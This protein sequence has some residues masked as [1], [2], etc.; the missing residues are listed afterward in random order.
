MVP[1]PALD[2]AGLRVVRLR[3]AVRTRIPAH[4]EVLRRILAI[5]P[6]VVERP[7]LRVL[8]MAVLFLGQPILEVPR[9]VEALRKIPQALAVLIQVRVRVLLA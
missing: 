8:E 4:R 7:Q 6:L 2:Q 3:A 1:T 9:M 5:R